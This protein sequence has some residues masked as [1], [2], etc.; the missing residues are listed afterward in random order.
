MTSA[1]LVPLLDT[2]A[3]SRHTAAQ[4]D[5]RDNILRGNQ[6]EGGKEKPEIVS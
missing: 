5:T 1:F 4:A 3:E 2:Q 6:V